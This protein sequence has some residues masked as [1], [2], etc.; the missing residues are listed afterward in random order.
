LIGAV[1]TI[2]NEDGMLTGYCTDGIG[3][4]LNLEDHGISVRNKKVVIAGAGGAGTAIQVQC[5]LSGAKEVVILKRKNKTFEKALQT[6]ERIRKAVPE[7]HVQVYDQNDEKKMTEEIQTAGIFVNATNVGMAPN[8]DESVIHDLSA[9]HPDLIV[10]DAV[11]NPLETRLLR[12]ARE[13]GCRTIDG[14]GMLLWQG[15]KAFSLFTGKQ[16]PVEQVRD[17]FFR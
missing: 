3:F 14:K 12:E 2:V 4:V 11:Y 10:A 5:A 13:A 9:F 17:N 7:C 6:A 1:K 15:V 16:M 8:A